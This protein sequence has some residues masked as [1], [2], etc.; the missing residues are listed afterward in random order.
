MPCLFCQLAAP[1]LPCPACGGCGWLSCCEGAVGGP[2]EV[3][4]TGA[5]G[6]LVDAETGISAMDAATVTVTP[7]PD[8]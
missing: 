1:G 4:N 7:L 6:A 3:T 8:G 2:Y 5:L